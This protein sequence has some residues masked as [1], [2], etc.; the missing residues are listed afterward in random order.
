[1]D[2]TYSTFCCL[3][4]L[5]FISPHTDTDKPFTTSQRATLCQQGCITKAGDCPA[6][7]DCPVFFPFQTHNTVSWRDF[8]CLVLEM[9]IKMIVWALTQ[10]CLSLLHRYGT[11]LTCISMPF[12]LI[13]TTAP[14]T[15]YHIDMSQRADIVWIKDIF[16]SSL[17]DFSK[18]VSFTFGSGSNRNPMANV[19]IMTMTADSKPAI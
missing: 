12:R 17:L 8:M 1:M 18:V 11:S 4:L 7:W 16:L 15:D 9:R 13:T 10:S 14:S 5:F 6:L 19:T 2:L 3:M